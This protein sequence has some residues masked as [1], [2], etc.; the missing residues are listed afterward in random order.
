MILATGMD[1]N[2]SIGVGKWGDRRTPERRPGQP[3]GPLG[4]RHQNIAGRELLARTCLFL[5]R[6]TA[7]LPSFPQP[8]GE[9]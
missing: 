8:S 2:A 4:L 5:E 3:V 9:Y 1:G 6:G 7:F